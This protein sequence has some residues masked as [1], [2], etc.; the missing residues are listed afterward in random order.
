MH[1]MLQL[2][3]QKRKDESNKNISKKE[4]KDI[5]RKKLLP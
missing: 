5:L 3:Y 4:N 1:V 2:P